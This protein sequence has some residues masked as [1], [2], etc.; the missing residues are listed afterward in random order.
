MKKLLIDKKDSY[1]RYVRE[2]HI[3][4]KSKK[5][6]KE[7]QELISTLKHPVRNPVR[8]SPGAEVEGMGRARSSQHGVSL[9]RDSEENPR[10]YNSENRNNADEESIHNE[11]PTER[12]RKRVVNY[13]SNR[14]PLP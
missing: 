9:G 6:E 10:R 12:A 3:P 11:S 4:N 13:R 2:M 14:P 5:K 8:I 1:A 7:L